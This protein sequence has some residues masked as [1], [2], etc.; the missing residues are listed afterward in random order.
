MLS[1]AVVDDEPVFQQIICGYI[2]QYGQKYH[3][4][5]RTTCFKDGLDIADEYKAKWD[6]IFW[7]SGWSIWTA[8]QLPDASD[9]LIRMWC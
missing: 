8:C 1:I 7:I 3:Q 9:P 6:I 2:E 5:F 4:Q